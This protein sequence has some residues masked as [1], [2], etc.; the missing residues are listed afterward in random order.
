MLTQGNDCKRQTAGAVV[1]PARASQSRVGIGRTSSSRRRRHRKP[2]SR[3]LR[4][5]PTQADRHKLC[6]P[7]VD[8][9]ERSFRLALLPALASGNVSAFEELYD[10]HSSTIFGLL[11]RG[12]AAN[13]DD[14]QEV[15]RE[16]FVKAWTSAAMFDAVRL[17]RVLWLIVARSRGIDRI[18][19]RKTRVEQEDEAGREISSSP[20]SWKR[21]GVD[22]A[23]RPRNSGR[24]RRARG[25]AGG[26]HRSRTGLLH[27]T[28]QSE[29]ATPLFETV[30]GIT[31]E[32]NRFFV[33]H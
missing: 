19:S 13:A 24:A 20:R 18:R 11:L 21:R 1:F 17:Q 31:D 5:H 8:E 12:P 14:A 16:T 6:A 25:T 26:W 22:S 4:R 2:R 30:L 15:L 3:D 10:R 29:I 9:L 28:P 32:G 23:I 7:K 27:Q 33:G